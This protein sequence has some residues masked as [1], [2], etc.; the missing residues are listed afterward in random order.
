MT[1]LR[2]LHVVH[3]FFPHH[4]HGVELSTLELAEAQQREG[5]H[6][7][8]LAGEF[9]RFGSEVALRKERVDNLRVLRLFFNP[10][11]ENGF[12]QHKGFS[13]VFS[14]TL[15]NLMPDVLH[16]QHL[17]NLS[18]E[19]I[20]S[21]HRLD[22][23]VIYSLR[24]FASFCQ[25]V[26]LIRGDG[27][28]CEQSDLVADCHRCLQSV[29]PFPVIERVAATLQAARHNLAKPRSWQ[30]GAGRLLASR[31]NIQPP[32]QRE[33]PADFA[34]RKAAVLQALGRVDV[35]LAISEDVAARTRAFLGSDL[36]IRV[37]HQAPDVR[38]LSW[39][40][41]L[42]G[43]APLR[44]GYIGKFARIKGL[45][46]LID[47]FRHL[48]VGTAELHIKGSPT[49]TD[50]RDIAFYR[51]MRKLADRPDIHFHTQPTPSSQIGDFYNRIDVLVVPSIWF[52]AF[53]R[54]VIE[55][56]ACG[57]PVICSDRGGVAELVR[58]GLDGLHFPLGD[59]E[60]LADILRRLIKQPEAVN[61][62][63]RHCRVSKTIQ[64]YNGEMEAIYRGAI[65]DHGRRKVELDGGGDEQ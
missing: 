60:A 3:Q 64:K 46:V 37:L 65:A 24:D 7:T 11:S 2:I 17:N 55:A 61:Y 29:E 50:L 53:G 31:S 20:H 52:E 40:E 39:R 19:I 35:L 48:P 6:V 13:E 30:L 57:V 10:R 43:G 49:W 8:I 45:E 32:V 4:R 25:R 14:S 28:L 62:L 36:P 22:I 21:A 27:S 33:T 56:Q 44:V 18:L 34:K 38:R 5:H 9:G 1:P 54:I 51:R 42:T 58:D 41:R 15:M 63:S 26:N 16:I 59:A 12:L 47:A 23:P